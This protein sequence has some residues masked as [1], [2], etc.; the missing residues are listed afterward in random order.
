MDMD[1]IHAEAGL[2]HRLVNLPEYGPEITTKTE[3]FYGVHCGDFWAAIFT[4]DYPSLS[5]HFCA[6]ASLEK[7]IELAGRVGGKVVR[8]TVVSSVSYSECISLG[9]D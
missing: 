7:S 3:Y 4:G 9:E 2:G 1:H 5:P 8:Q 6:E